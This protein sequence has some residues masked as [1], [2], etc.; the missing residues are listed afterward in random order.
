MLVRWL[1]GLAVVALL[2]TSSALAIEH[3]REDAIKFCKDYVH[4]NPVTEK[5]IKDQLATLPLIGC[6]QRVYDAAHLEAHKRQLVVRATLSVKS[7]PPEWQTT[8]VHP[9]V[10]T[11]DLKVWV[12]G[13]KQSFDSSGNCGVQGDGLFCLGSLSAAEADECRSTGD[14]VRQCRIVSNDGSFQ[15]ERRAAGVLVTIRQRLELVQA[16][17]DGGPFLYLSPTNRENHDFL[18]PK[19]TPEV[20]G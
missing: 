11:G 18:L 9:S 2:F 7:A 6:Y 13:R 12:S 4:E 16:P 3:T 19:A 15:V 10:A 20:C 8:K 14:G 5:C 1:V 17:Y